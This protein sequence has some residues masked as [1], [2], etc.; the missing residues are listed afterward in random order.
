MLS[1][2][3]NATAPVAPKHFSADGIRLDMQ[4][5]PV[6]PSNAMASAFQQFVGETFFQLMLKSLHGMHDKP[7]YLH[8]G[9]AETLFQS[10]LDQEIA[11]QLSQTK[12]GSFSQDLYQVFQSQIKS[13]V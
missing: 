7:A 5:K 3:P 6:A 2:A 12:V 9:H 13:P 8:G 4:G 11:S 1:L 10:Q